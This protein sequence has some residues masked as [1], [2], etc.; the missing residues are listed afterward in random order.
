L[1]ICLPIICSCQKQDST[2]EQELAKQKTE[3]DARE[4]ALDEK[5]NALDGKLKALDERVR[6]LA[7]NQKAMASGAANLTGVQGG[8]PDPAQEQAERERIQQFSAQMRARMADPTRLKAEKAEKERRSQERRAQTQPSLEQ[9][10]SQKQ[11]KL[12]MY[13]GAV[14]PAPETNQ[15]TPSSTVEST[16]PN[17]YPATEVSSPTESPTPE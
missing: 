3:L 9:L 7:D 2:T 11:H 6:A 8:T 14:F 13:S 1:L 4:D 5:I 15:P 12:K 17:P 16:A 10:Q